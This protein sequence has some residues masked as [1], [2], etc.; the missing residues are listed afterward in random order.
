MESTIIVFSFFS[1]DTVLHRHGGSAAW[2]LDPARAR[3][4]DYVLMSRNARDERLERGATEPHRSAFLVGRL[5]EV[6]PD[7]ERPQRY[8][9]KFS[10]YA[11]V[12]VPDVWSGNRNPVA[13]GRLQDFGINPDALDWQPMPELAEPAAPAAA[14]QATDFAT[15]IG[16]HKTAIA[17]ALGVPRDAVEISIRY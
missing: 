14:A 16:Q 6:V 9:L 1:I 13:Y 4:C 11:L 17:E 10:D 15:I 8:L 12:D 2:H 3:Q 7:S 5:S